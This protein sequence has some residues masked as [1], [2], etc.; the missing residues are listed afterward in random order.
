MGKLRTGQVETPPARHPAGASSIRVE[1]LLFASVAEAIG[2][3]RRELELPGGATVRDVFAGLVQEQPRL[4]RLVDHVSFAR[5][6]EF[7]PGDTRLSEG[8]ELAIIPPVSGGA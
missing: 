2:E 8:D 5:N 3:R 6:R 7:V 4:E 1:L